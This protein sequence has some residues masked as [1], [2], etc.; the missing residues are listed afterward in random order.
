MGLPLASDAQE[1]I[2]ALAYWIFGKNFK[3]EHEVRKWII[4]LLGSNE[5]GDL[6]ADL[7]LHGVAKRGYMIPHVMDMLAGTV[8][9]DRSYVPTFDRSASISGGA[10]LPIEVGKLLGPPLQSPEKTIASQAQKASG[11]VFSTGFVAYNAL[12]NSQLDWTDFKRWEGMFPRALRNVSQAVRAASSG[13]SRTKTGGN[14]VEYNVRDP[15]GAAEVIGMAMGYRPYR[16]NYEWEKAMSKRDAAKMIDIRREQ[17]MRQF[18]NAVLGK[19]PEERSKMQQAVR[20]FNA[21][22]QP[23]ERGKAI[24]SESLTQSVETRARDRALQE[25]GLPVKKGDVPIYRREDQLYPGQNRT[26]RTVPKGM[27]P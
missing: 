5:A 6:T 21:Q 11:A 16:E 10:M 1:W 15:Q 26:I 7:M 8:G 13:G 4:E 23:E 17:V 22:L 3:L 18:G 27:Q 14:I 20:E 12:Y 24:T 19:D 9:L 25:R 2:Q